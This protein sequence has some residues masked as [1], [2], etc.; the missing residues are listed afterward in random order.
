[1]TRQRAVIGHLGQLGGGV[2]VPEQLESV[3]HHV[4]R[5]CSYQERYWIFIFIVNFIFSDGKYFLKIQKYL[6]I[7]ESES[8]ME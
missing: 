3:D 2:V 7:V 4:V 1:M 8:V 5:T 6:L